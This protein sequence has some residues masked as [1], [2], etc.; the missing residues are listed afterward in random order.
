MTNL[1]QSLTRH[2]RSEYVF[3]KPDGS[4]YKDL[5]ESFRKACSHVGIEDFVFHDFRHTAITN[6]RRAGINHLTIMKISGHKTMSVFNRYNTVDKA[7]LQDASAR[8]DIYMDS[9]NDMDTNIDTRES[10]ALINLS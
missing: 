9:C 7:D 6:M 10:K 1:L 2:I 3:C 8:L 4:P 5:K